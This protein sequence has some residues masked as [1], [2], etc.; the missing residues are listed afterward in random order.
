MCA[1]A[2]A[3]EHGKCTGEQVVRGMGKQHGLR[4]QQASRE[5]GAASRE[6]GAESV[7]RVLHG[8]LMHHLPS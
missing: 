1:G 5:Q 2:R 3:G 6:Q 8:P 7:R 4:R